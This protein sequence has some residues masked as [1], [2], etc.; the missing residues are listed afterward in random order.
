MGLIS[1][2]RDQVAKLESRLDELNRPNLRRMISVGTVASFQG[3]EFPLVVLSCVRSN[4]EGRVG[5]LKPLQ[6]TNVAM[7]RA[8]RQLI[9]VGD[10]KT[11]ATNRE[12]VGSA[13][14]KQAFDL[15]R[16]WGGVVGSQDVEKAALR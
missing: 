2:Y 4:A 9:V 11:L 16:A 14:L 5:F 12:N 3:H 1:F 6:H 7:S 8:Q 15:I 10:S 13:Q